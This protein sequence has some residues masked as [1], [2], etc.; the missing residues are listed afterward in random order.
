MWQIGGFS[1]TLFTGQSPFWRPWPVSSLDRTCF[2]KHRSFMWSCGCSVWWDQYCITVKILWHEVKARIIVLWI[3]A[4]GTRCVCEIMFDPFRPSL[5][6]CACMEWCGWLKPTVQEKRCVSLHVCVLSLV[7]AKFYSSA[8]CRVLI[9]NCVFNLLLKLLQSLFCVYRS[10]FCCWRDCFL[11]QC[12]SD[13]EDS[14]YTESGDHMSAEQHT[15]E[16]TLIYLFRI[17]SS[18]TFMMGSGGFPNC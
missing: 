8:F 5:H 7:D 14:N 12:L 15:T 3:F 17:Q 6:S 11:S 16:G 1:V 9:A 2:R 18:W 13:C 4:A 10:V